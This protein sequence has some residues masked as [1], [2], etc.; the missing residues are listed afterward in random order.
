MP[1]ETTSI[2]LLLGIYPKE[3]IEDVHIYRGAHC[4]PAT[5]NEK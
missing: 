4:G 5:N 2:S 3:I 1:F